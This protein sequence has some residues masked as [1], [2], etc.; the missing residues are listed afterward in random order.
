MKTRKRVYTP[1]DDGYYDALDR[2]VA[3]YEAACPEGKRILDRMLEAV[4]AKQNKAAQTE[5][6][7][8]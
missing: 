2:F 4:E 7:D 1:H 8:L 3:A 5:K 6:G